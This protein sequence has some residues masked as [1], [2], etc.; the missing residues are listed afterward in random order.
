MIIAIIGRWRKNSPATQPKASQIL[1]FFTNFLTNFTSH[2]TGFPEKMFPVDLQKKLYYT[3]CRSPVTTFL[4]RFESKCLSVPVNFVSEIKS[5]FFWWGLN[6]FFKLTVCVTQNV[7][8]FFILI[9]IFG[10][11]TIFQHFYTFITSTETL[12]FSRKYGLQE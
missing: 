9:K 12:N 8:K 2:F 10:N 1:Q 6:N 3:I 11:F 4:K 7:L 5:A